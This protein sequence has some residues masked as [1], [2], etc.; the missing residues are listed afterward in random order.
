MNPDDRKDILPSVDPNPASSSGAM[1]SA[2]VWKKALKVMAWTVAGVF[3]VFVVVCSA[4]VW[5]LHP[6][7]LTPIIEKVASDNLNADVKIDRAELTFWS[8]FPRLKV[9]VSGLEVISRSLDGLSDSVRASLPA[10]ADSLISVG[11]FNGSVNVLSLIGGSISLS[12]VII[13]RPRINLIQV[14][15]SVSNFNIIPASEPDTAKSSIPD[16][17]INH[18]AIT[19]A[20]P[21]TYR[22]LADSVGM[23]VVL[24]MIDLS[25]DKAPLYDLSVSSESEIGVPMLKEF[26]YANVRIG[27][28]TSVEWSYDDPCRVTLRDF[29]LKT[30]D[31]DVVVNMVAD[32]S[33]RLRI[34]DLNL[35]INNLDVNSMKGHVPQ[36]LAPLLKTLDTDM[37]VNVE[38]RLKKPF[39]FSD[40]MAIP[41]IAAMLDIPECRLYYGKARFNKFAARIGAELKGDSLNFSTV[42]I[43]RFVI[44]G[45][46]MD[47]SLSC[48][49][50]DLFTDPHFMGR[51]CGM[52]DF[53]RLPS[54]LKEKLKM[55][56]TGRLDADTRFN[57]RLSDF[58]RD[59]FHRLYV[60][61]NVRLSDVNFLTADTATGFYSR[62][63]RLEFGTG[64]SFSSAGNRVDSLLIVKL[65]ADTARFFTEDVVAELRDFQAGAGSSNTYSSSDTAKINPFG[66]RVRIGS[67]KYFS[68]IDSAMVVLRDVDGTASL[69]RFNGHSRVPELGLKMDIGRMA[70]MSKSFS[71]MLRDT[72]S[73]I[74]AHFNPRRRRAA[75]DS[76]RPRRSNRQT[77]MTASQL[78]SIGVETMDFGVDNSLRNLLRR[79]KLHGKISSERGFLRFTSARIRNRFDSLEL[80]FTTDSVAL[81]NV[82]YRLGRS[83]FK[84]HGAV[85]NIIRALNTKRPGAIKFDMDISSDTINVNEIA[86]V[87][88]SGAG[89]EYHADSFSDDES[90]T[91]DEVELIPQDSVNVST[92]PL[93]VPVNID[94]R[95]DIRAENVVY[96][97]LLLNGFKGSLMVYQGAV[98]LN[99]LSGRNDAGEFNISALYSAPTAGNIRFGMG[100]DLRK[101]HID[102]LDQMIP[103]IDSILPML[104][105][106]EGVIDADI[107]ATVDIDDGMNLKMPS[108]RAAMRFSGDSLVVF[109]NQTFRTLS[110][111]LMFKN[112]QKNMIDSL[113][114]ELT[115][116]DSQM[117]IYPFI[118]NI[119]RYR[120]GIMGYNDMAMNMDYHVSVLKSPLPFKFGINVKGDMDNPKIRLGGAKFKEKMVAEHSA[121]ADTTRVNLVEQINSVFRRGVRAARLGPLQIKGRR[122]EGFMDSA[123]EGIS[124]SDSLA[125]IRE[126]LIELPDSLNVI[127]GKSDG[128]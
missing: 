42:D 87:F 36:S 53:D 3:I 111:W 91:E 122:P 34:D 95:L 8:S 86:R 13:D 64:Q 66:G 119:D 72:R 114:V 99:R 44:D 52:V 55:T 97:D 98:Q 29:V 24:S 104:Q 2:G 38:A 15:D 81:S 49:L 127:K 46:A 93:L 16:I 128:K 4:V 107:A 12:D 9:E 100:M 14:N 89:G 108:L 27:I 63:S 10:N 78:D 28:D 117:S 74:T 85:Y 126:G 20:L 61:G 71:T 103:A 120:L 65:S 5:F 96:S 88:L 105:S 19:N 92:G 40:T 76:I 62:N 37:K 11:H 43:E 48:R 31:V 41:S 23:T 39:V 101:F 22:S 26:G 109:D 35:K 69:R 56:L 54:I 84:I 18:F 77:R 102:R 30:D 94:A 75:G 1:T 118:V 50:K 110:K 58:A 70:I 59:R 45:R 121:I 123:E 17:S 73:D 67:L 60:S 47:V 112:K 113:D 25:G 51:F 90:W 6:D 82:N 125:M 83:D 21:F 68:T 106:F 7:R 79:W 32:F 57:F 33:D 116:S 115:I 80:V 124:H